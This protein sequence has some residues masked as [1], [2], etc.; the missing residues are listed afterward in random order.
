LP[1]FAGG[2]AEAD[3]DFGCIGWIWMSD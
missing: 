2:E 1:A 3:E